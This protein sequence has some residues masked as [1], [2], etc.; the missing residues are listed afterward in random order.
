[1]KPSELFLAILSA[2]AKAAAH[3]S[4]ASL[5]TYYQLFGAAGAQQDAACCL[6]AIFYVMLTNLINKND[7]L[8]SH[9]HLAS[10]KVKTT[11]RQSASWLWH[12]PVCRSLTVWHVQI[13]TQVCSACSNDCNALPLL[14]PHL[15]V[16]GLQQLVQDGLNI[17]THITS[18]AQGAGAGWRV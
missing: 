1:M 13:I 8:L 6:H 9:F 2:A 18:L 17:V 4:A 10:S 15:E 7:A 5:C 16:A 3:D 11:S 12:S 14:C